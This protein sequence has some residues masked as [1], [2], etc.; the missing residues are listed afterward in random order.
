[1][2]GVA[3][4]RRGPHPPGPQAPDPPFRSRGIA[5]PGPESRGW[6]YGSHQP[7]PSLV[8]LNAIATNQ[9]HST[10]INTQADHAGPRGRRNGAGGWGLGAG[11][12][13]WGGAQNKT[14]RSGGRSGGRSLTG[15]F[16]K[17]AFLHVVEEKAGQKAGHPV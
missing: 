7:R 2:E 11:A 15:H 5:K 6:G 9:E 16:Q 10:R 3:T 17:N 8:S 4:P 12:K 1:M 14:G 13:G